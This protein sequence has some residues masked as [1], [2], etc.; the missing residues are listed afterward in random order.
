MEC[1]PESNKK[2]NYFDKNNTH[3]T[4]KNYNNN[5]NNNNTQAPKKN[6]DNNKSSY[7]CNSIYKDETVIAEFDNKSKN[8]NVSE[9]SLYDDQTNE[10]KPKKQGNWRQ[11]TTTYNQW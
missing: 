10:N 1:F 3:D 8:N 6:Y 2:K 9:K 5:N 7:P 11:K 4:Q